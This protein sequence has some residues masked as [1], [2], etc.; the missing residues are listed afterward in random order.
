MNEEG[1]SWIFATILSFFT[2]FSAVFLM[3]FF[4]SNGGDLP[5][6]SEFIGSLEFSERLFWFLSCV[7]LLAGVVSFL[8]VIVNIAFYSVYFV[9]RYWYL[10]KLRKPERVYTGDPL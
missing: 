3:P 8:Y 6:G 10:R 2:G 4:Y 5:L 9:Q 7:S 1:K